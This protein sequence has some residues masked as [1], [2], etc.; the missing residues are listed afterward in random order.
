MP[1]SLI[2]L[3]DIVADSWESS[4]VW[5]LPLTFNACIFCSEQE[6]LELFCPSKNTGLYN[7]V[8]FGS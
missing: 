1:I 8:L 3:Y 4:P 2:I 6:E 5:L 7:R